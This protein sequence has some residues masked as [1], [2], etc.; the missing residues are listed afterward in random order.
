MDTIAAIST[1]L[2]IGAISIIRI[3]GEESINIVNSIFKGKNLNLVKSHTINYGYIIENNEII[4][5]VLVSVMHTPK[6]FTKENIVEINCHGG[7]STTNK[8]LALLLE[9]GCRLAEPG[10]FSKRAFLNGRI[11]LTESEAI[12]DLINAKNEMAR[13]LSISQLTGTLSNMIKELRQEILE[14]LASI[15]VN[16][17]YPEYE[18]IIEITNKILKPKIK[19]IKLTLKKILKNSENSQIVKEGIKTVIIGKPNV[20]KS[21]LLNKLLEEEK[22]IVTD[23]AGTTRDIVEGTIKIDEILLKIID[24]AG[25]RDTTNVIEKIGVS[26]S[27]ELIE[28]SDLV[29]LVLNNNEIITEKENELI[30]KIKSKPYIIIVNKIDLETK[31]NLTDENIVKISIKKDLGI[32]ELKNK[33]KDLFNLDKITTDDLNYMTNARSIAL[34]KKSLNIIE[35]I[36]ISIKENQLIDIIEIDIKEVWSL[37]GEIIGETYQEELIDQLFSQFCL[38]K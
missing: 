19:R 32:T 36:E 25:I 34:I 2:G 6:T 22:A 4:D 29:L 17:D 16:I 14:I 10:E 5:E 7:I 9:K 18:D 35:K 33:I 1:A 28:K 3:S 13:K 26:K 37:L 12:M 15:E 27:L 24:T 11:D 8:I 31:I 21:S 23:I 30:K 20:G 38:G